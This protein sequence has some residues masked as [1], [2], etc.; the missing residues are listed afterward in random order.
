MGAIIHTSKS[1]I[2][3][4]FSQLP[5]IRFNNSYLKSIFLNLITNAIKY[6]RYDEPPVIRIYSERH[7][8]RKQL[9]V[10]DNGAGFD[11]AKVKDDL[12]RLPQKLNSSSN[13][14]GIGLYLIYSHVTALGG[15]VEID[16][17]IGEGTTVVIRFAD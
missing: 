9:T 15:D 10:S 3:A 12:F 4:D 16:S 13:S 14:T 7:A 8:G 1:T 5:A 11:A 17:K 2:L 6:A